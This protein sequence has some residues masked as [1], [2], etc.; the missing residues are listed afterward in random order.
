MTEDR[1][2]S[3]GVSPE[4]LVKHFPKLYHMA[5][6]S[7]WGSIKRHGL[8]STAAL[9]D[10]FQIRGKRRFS[11]ESSHRPESM[12]ISH[13]KHGTAVIRDQKPMRESD[14]LGCLADMSPQ[15]WYES[16]NKKV[17]FWLTTERLLRL[18]QAKEYRSNKQLVLTVDTAMLLRRHS[19]RVSLSALNTGCTRPYPWPRS[20]KTFLP[21]DR[22]PFEERKRLGVKNTVVELTVDYAV[23][24]IGD[25]VIKA[26]YMIGKQQLETLY[27]RP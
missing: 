5:D 11:I 3:K 19:E 18:L 7:S 4:T 17:F 12:V 27:E 9:L 8:L 16:L 14:L 10:L 15:Q 13:P 20:S 25:L 1:G 6:A 21:L 23:T 22:Y 24:D 2:E 26:E